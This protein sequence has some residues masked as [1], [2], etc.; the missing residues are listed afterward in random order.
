MK[1]K[2]DYFGF[3]SIFWMGVVE[4]R[5]DPIKLARVRVRIF[6]WHSQETS[7]VPKEDLPWAQIMHPTTSSV[8]GGVGVDGTGLREGDW[9]V[10][11]FLDGPTA[12][13]PV[14]LGALSGMEATGFPS[15]NPLSANDEDNAP[16]LPDTKN[17]G[18]SLAVPTATGES[19]D[20]PES[21]YNALYPNNHVYQSESGH[22]VEYDDTPD[23][24]RIHQYHK[25]GTFYEIDPG[26]NRVTRVVAD[27]YQVVAGNNYV[28]VM[29]N[30]NLTIDSNCTTYVKGNWDILIDGNLTQTVKGTMTETV[31]GDVTETYQSNQTLAITGNVTEF[32][33]GN[34]AETVGGNVTEDVSGNVAETVGGNSTENISGNQ[35]ITASAIGHN[36]DTYTVDS[37]GTVNISGSTVNLN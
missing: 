31:T 34:V 10:G 28:H 29:G 5:E 32:V 9:V 19:W 23:A 15:T 25:A 16:T 30:V 26:G 21:A 13:Q 37:A 3:N 7:E 8:T 1:D 27:D 4:D 36:A 17:E 2:G 6:G 33:D 14:I 20:E 12:R 18:R 24:E 35:S 22:V 11:M